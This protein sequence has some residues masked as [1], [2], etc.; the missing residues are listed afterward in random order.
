MSGDTAVPTAKGERYA[1]MDVLR[2][3]AL[4]GVMLIKT[5]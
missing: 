1:V 5:F 2:G 3:F 4:F